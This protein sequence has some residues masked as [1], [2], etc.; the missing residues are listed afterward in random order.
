MAAS[1]SIF[2]LYL[3]NRISDTRT[4]IENAQD[5]C[6]QSIRL[7]Q[8]TTPVAQDT[9]EKIPCFTL[10]TWRPISAASTSRSLTVVTESRY[11]SE[12]FDIKRLIFTFI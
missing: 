10:R 3:K 1:Y 4:R 9:Y 5:T 7:L 11:A 12:R 6:L 2:L 8:S